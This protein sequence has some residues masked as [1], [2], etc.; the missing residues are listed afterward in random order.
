MKTMHRRLHLFKHNSTRFR[1]SQT[2]LLAA[3]AHQSH[4]K[5]PLQSNTIIGTLARDGCEARAERGRA[6]TYSVVH[7]F[8]EM[9]EIQLKHILLKVIVLVSHFH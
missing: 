2:T 9:N 5:R 6:R 8:E 4:R 7:C 1:G 3:D